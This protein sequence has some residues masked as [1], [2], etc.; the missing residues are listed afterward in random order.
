MPKFSEVLTIINGKNQKSVENPNGKYPI[1]GS[2]GIMGYADHYICHA[3]TVIIG[4]KGNINHPI[5][6]ETPFW[7]VD[8]AFGLEANQNKLFPKYL[9]Y[10]CLNFDF[11]KLNTTVTI[12]SLTKQNLLKINLPLPPLETQKQIADT[13][14]KVTRT[15]DLCHAMLEK[16][17]LLVKSRFVEMFGEI[18][19]T[20]QKSEWKPISALGTV[21]GGSTPKTS[22]EDFWNGNLKWITPAE[23]SLDTGYLY[24]SVRKITK[25]G[26]NSCSLQL[27][28]KNTV[29]LTSRAPIGKVAILGAEM[30]CN[31]GFKNIICNNT[32]IPQYLYS[33]LLYNTDFLNSLGRGATFKEISKSIV[34]QI[35]I[36]VPPIA[37]QQQFSDFVEKVNKSKSTIKQ[38]L[39]QAEMLKKSLM[40]EYFC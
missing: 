19:L 32:I 24:D 33:I 10:F 40:Q 22:V 12:P 36:P 28:P 16:L 15:I 6:V 26:A 21:V 3:D 14:D 25:A 13:L 38:T 29:I 34:E 39:A 9:Y 35:R 5:Y 4:R 23:L 37:L 1:Y 18:N 17:D 2:G 7:N 20:P 8:T 11:E 27:L 31:Q 30:Y